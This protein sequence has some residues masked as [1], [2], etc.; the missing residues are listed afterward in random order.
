MKPI[1]AIAILSGITIV[2]GCAPSQQQYEAATELLRGSKKAEQYAMQEC[3]T[4]GWNKTNVHAASM[5]LDVSERAAPRLACTRIVGAM[6]SGR[7]QYAD[8]ASF[9]RGRPT[10][11]MIKILQGR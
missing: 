9:R 4:K 5:M 6:K 1:L 10:P 2:A 11:E 3:L 7:M 8:A